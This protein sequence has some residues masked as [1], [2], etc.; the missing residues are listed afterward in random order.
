MKKLKV[1][2]ISVKALKI[3]DFPQLFSLANK[4]LNML[5]M[6]LLHGYDSF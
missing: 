6:V 1:T 5:S 3:A 2:S 4:V